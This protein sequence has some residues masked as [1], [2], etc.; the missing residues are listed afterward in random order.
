MKSY[1]S[2]MKA[3]LQQQQAFCLEN[4]STTIREL[5]NIYW[6]NSLHTPYD[7]MKQTVTKY[8][9]VN[10][11]CLKNSMPSLLDSGNMVSLAR[12]DYSYC[13]IR[14]KLE[15]AKAPEVSVYIIY[16]NWNE[17][18]GWHP[19]THSL[20]MDFK[21]LDL[22]VSKVGFL[23]SKSQSNCYVRQWLVYYL[24]ASL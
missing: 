17:E 1:S 11:K 12:Q 10:L 3:S 2:R 7:L 18:R 4:I 20:E 22:E 6:I 13:F 9:W 16:L 21:F 8:P 15:A 24:F 19:I 23:V 5:D 14:L